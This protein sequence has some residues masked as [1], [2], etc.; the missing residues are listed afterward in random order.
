MNLQIALGIIVI[1]TIL[2]LSQ[3]C[4]I[5]D[6]FL[7]TAFLTAYAC[8]VSLCR[9]I[10][11]YFILLAVVNDTVSLISLSDLSL[12]LYRNARDFCV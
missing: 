2:I 11:R 9:L 6:I 10:P 4:I 3:Y 7:H 8:F 12:V 1:F 5:F